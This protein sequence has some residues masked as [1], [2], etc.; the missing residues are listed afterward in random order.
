MKK[1]SILIINRVYPPHRGATGRM[2]ENLARYL[3]AE[4][5]NV[6]VLTTGVKKSS[7]L[8]KDVFVNRVKAS[9]EP[10][11]ALSYFFIGLKL[12]FKALT[13]KRVDIVITMTDPPLLGI[14]G[15]FYA[16]Y[17]KS[18]HVHWSQDVY[19]DLLPKIQKSLPE[20]I[21]S[22]VFG[23]SR[24]MMNKASRVIVI[25]RC[26]SK[27]LADTGVDQSKINII[28]NWPDPQIFIPEEKGGPLLSPEAKPPEKMFRDDSPKFRILYAGNIGL[29]HDVKIIID[30]A[31]ILAEHKEIEFVFIGSSPAH[32]NLAQERSK[33]GLDNIKFMPYQPP[34]LLKNILESGD[35]HLVS[36][37]HDTQGLLVPCKFYGALAVGR[38]TIF[39]G[40]QESEIAQ[41]LKEYKAGVTVLD[42]TAQTVVDAILYYRH[43]GKAWFDAQEGAISASQDYNAHVSLSHWKEELEKIMAL[44]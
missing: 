1:Y 34:H 21:Q 43:D 36:Q 2:A 11:A 9:Q 18:K 10:Q 4:G 24:K 12:M 20:K 7:S 15:R 6:R 28:P 32:D 41:V 31:K 17:N 40:P 23:M 35:I 25:G 27:H 16:W 44:Q 5:W 38:P 8:E 33:E 14:I 37:R 26:M 22:V 29:A 13:L 39:I 3:T 42:N 30:A 19:P